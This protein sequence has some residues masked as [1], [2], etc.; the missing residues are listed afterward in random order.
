MT[1]AQID[2]RDLVDPV[3]DWIARLPES[4]YELEDPESDSEFTDEWRITVRGP[5]GETYIIEQSRHEDYFG[6][7]V[8]EGDL[9]GFGFGNNSDIEGIHESWAYIPPQTYESSGSKL[10]FI[11]VAGNDLKITL[12]IENDI[13][14]LTARHTDWGPGR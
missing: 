5:E 1:T 8:P 6:F 14:Y 3:R 4:A 7:T 11:A 13:A 10:S 9:M 2:S 12:K